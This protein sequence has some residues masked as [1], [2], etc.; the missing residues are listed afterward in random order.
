VAKDATAS[1]APRTR[2]LESDFENNFVLMGSPLKFEI[3]RKCVRLLRV[4]IQEF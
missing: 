2:D 1:S 3:S 4:V